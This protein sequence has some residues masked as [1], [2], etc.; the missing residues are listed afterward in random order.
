M[1][2]AAA[3]TNDPNCMTGRPAQPCAWCHFL[4]HGHVQCAASL[5]IN[6][7]GR[8]LIRHVNGS[9]FRISPDGLCPKL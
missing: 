3:D 2:G 1:L 8:L 9:S 6:F 4:N 5:M 7:Q